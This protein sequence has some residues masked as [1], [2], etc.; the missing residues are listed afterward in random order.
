MLLNRQNFAQENNVMTKYQILCGTSVFFDIEL[1]IT[2][3]LVFNYFLVYLFYK[4]YYLFGFSLTVFSMCFSPVIFCLY[5]YYP[6]LRT[7]VTDLVHQK[8]L[9]ILIFGILTFIQITFEQFMLLFSK[10]EK[11]ILF[12]IQKACLV[13][14]I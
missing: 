12:I 13:T 7:A 6:L 2:Y 3:L 5:V 9:L 14:L 8:I 1:K 10:K 11:K 4:Q